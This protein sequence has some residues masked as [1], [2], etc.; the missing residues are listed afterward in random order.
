M[1]VVAL[2]GRWADMVQKARSNPAGLRFSDLCHLV[3]RAGFV[4]RNQKGSHIIYKH[5]ELTGLRPLPLQ[6]GKSDKAKP[7]QVRQF[8]A[9]L[10]EYG[11][12]V[13]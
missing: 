10:D 3:E 2:M 5:P 6:K 8:L 13:K 11:L 4:K 1:E 7:Y 9:I 12:E